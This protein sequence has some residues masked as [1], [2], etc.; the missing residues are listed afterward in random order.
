M[1]VDLVKEYEQIAKD[2][3]WAISHMRPPS[4]LIR[5]MKATAARCRESAK[6]LRATSHSLTQG[7]S[8]N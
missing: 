2:A 4:H 3:E 6:R 5:S 7:L 8:G 1:V